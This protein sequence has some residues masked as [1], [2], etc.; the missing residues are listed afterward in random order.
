[1]QTRYQTVKSN[2]RRPD[3]DGVTRFITKIY[4]KLKT[5]HKTP[6][7]ATGTPLFCHF[8]PANPSPL[9]HLDR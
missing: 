9:R 8:V 7:P 2:R 6:I 4:D 3:P 5:S 1:M